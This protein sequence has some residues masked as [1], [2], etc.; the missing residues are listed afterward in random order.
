[1]L[2]HY[3]II[4][5]LYVLCISGNA[6][7]LLLS[8]EN[9]RNRFVCH[10]HFVP[11]DF[12]SG[13]RKLLKRTACP[14]R[15]SS[16]PLHVLTPTKTYTRRRN[17]DED[18]FQ[19]QSTSQ[20]PIHILT[21]PIASLSNP[22]T[23]S[24][25]KQWVTELTKQP[26]SPARLHVKRKLEF[27][28]A[29]DTPTKRKLRDSL[30]KVKED[31][32][33][34]RVQITRFK[35]SAASLKTRL[36]N[37]N[38][39]N[40][41]QSTKFISPHAKALVRM[42]LLHR[43]KS[44]WLKDERDFCLGL[45]FKSPATFKMLR[46][47]I[48]L[49]SVS[50]IKLWICKTS[51]FR[52]GFSNAYIHN[53]SLK[54]GTMTR[55]EKY[56]VLLFDEMALKKFL[57]YSKAMDFIEGFEDLGHLGRTNKFAKEAL[58]FFVRGMFLSWKFPFTYFLSQSAT[59]GNILKDLILAVL[60][61]LKEIGLNVKAVVC[62]QGTNNRN[63]LKLLGVTEPTRPFFLDNDGNKYY[64][65][66]D[67]PH[68]MKS[69]R[70]NLLNGNYILDNE[71]ISFSDVRDTYRID[72][73]SQTGARSMVKI[74]SAHLNPNPF[75]KLS[76]KLAVQIFSHSVSSAIQTAVQTGV[77]NSSTAL[78][79]A[80]FLTSCNNL[81]DCLNSVQRYNKNPYACALSQN[82][83]TVEQTLISCLEMFQ[84][85]KKVDFKAKCTVSR[86][87]CFDGFVSTITAVLDI[88]Y[89]LLNEGKLFLLTSKLNQDPLENYFSIVRQKG[90]YNKNPT[91]RM[92][93]LTF[94]SLTLTTFLKPISDQSNCAPDSDELV[95]IG[96]PSDQSSTSTI[97]ISQG[98][99]SDTEGSGS[100]TMSSTS[101]DVSIAETIPQ[102]KLERCSIVYFA[103]YLVKKMYDKF[104]CDHC[105]HALTKANELLN[106]ADEI[107]LINRLYDNKLSISKGL[108]APS[109][110][111]KVVTE[112]GFDI[113][114]RHR[115]KNIH[116][117]LIGKRIFKKILAK[118]RSEKI[119]FFHN[120]EHQ[121]HREYIIEILVRVLL[122]Y[123]CKQINS[124]GSKNVGGK[125]QVWQHK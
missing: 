21:P 5:Q 54:V 93:R 108:M 75:Q 50:T 46:K 41:L 19:G 29:S 60:K 91:V 107:L 111:Q 99:D 63:A 66:Y 12:L 85:I 123:Q 13:N 117:K 16:S 90:G 83:P 121:I 48:I 58:V 61:K 43:N 28:V 51:K 106:D 52:P 14:I 92:F 119:L 73:R 34:K 24:A 17:D 125:L 64:T 114:S 86:P 3:N 7:L 44:K 77:L 56:C 113:F 102:T 55:N 95:N 112:I 72:Q 23:S 57:E 62:D 11:E 10:N 40:L 88:Y 2:L 6:A 47:Q 30:G 103:G 33:K 124:S 89:E 84:K 49:P 65:I 100:D 53:L 116:K 37:F 68:L 27:P 36:S 122:Y 71:I 97:F 76:V 26:I 79:T 9:L 32:K 18:E 110:I 25:D 109:D 22:S 105:E 118:L 81:F 31:L 59:S 4:F 101:S 96:Q 82:T 115:C 74:T 94:R 20:A 45:Y 87:P 80:N 98:N 70:N 120:D 39:N 8:P 15:F 38:V 42:Q 104:N 35:K 1:M 67:T 69:I 78:T